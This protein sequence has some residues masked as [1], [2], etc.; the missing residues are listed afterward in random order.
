M[1]SQIDKVTLEVIHH[2]LVSI[3]DEMETI[4][5]KS[6]FSTIVKEARDATTALFDAKART[7]AQACA[8]PI[9]LGTMMTSVPQIIDGLFS[10]VSE[11]QEG[12][13]Y[14]AN[15]PY[16]GGT[17]MPDITMVTPVIYEDEV[18]AFSC[19][20]VHHQDMG[21]VTGGGSASATSI[22]H[23]GLNLPPVK[24]IVA[25]KPVKGIHDIIRKNV[26]TPD[27]V[28]GDLHAQVAAGNVGRLRILEL[29]EEYGKKMALDAMNQLL[30]YSEALTREE[31]RNMPDKSYSFVDYLDNDG[32]EL[33]KSVKLQIEVTIRGSDFIVDFTG[34]NPQ[35]KGPINCTPSGALAASTYV[36]RAI[37]DRSIPNNDGCFRVIKLILPEESIVNPISP[38]P[39]GGRAMTIPRMTDTIFGALVKAVPERLPAC[40][41]G[42]L[43]AIIWFAGKDP[44]TGKEY[45][46]LEVIVA[47]QGARPNKDGVD[48]VTQ[49]VM[50][51]TNVPI[52]AAE[53]SFPYRVLKIELREDSGGAGEYRGGLGMVKV[54]ELLRGQA[55]LICRGERFYTQPWGVFGG[56]PGS[57]ASAFVLRKGGK[58][59]IIPSKA[60]LAL[61]EGDQFHVFT[62]GGGGYGDPLKRS[63]ESVLRDVLDRR[64]SIESAAEEY[65]VVIDRVSR[66]I[67]FKKTRQLRKEKA[68]ARG[69]VTWT[70]DRGADGKI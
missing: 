28:I 60:D 25:G 57:N 19:S 33:E 61:N 62:P 8:I 3:A 54:F 53:M 9:H 52:E 37:T 20:V 26:R 59:E 31:I 35:V 48:A 32:I 11:M 70:Y 50:N 24:F 63:P 55:T 13:A 47:G 14:I 44:L 38:A 22:Y 40:S 17:H 12:D 4:L 6:S 18:V 68:K 29:I 23:E 51:L 66:N 39:V 46:A 15:D 7:I 64:V 1:S 69:P 49:D 5:L 41:G 43:G 65:G 2:R 42:G 30:D 21:A 67:D 10:S 36:L 34:S 16:S 58:K 56:L 45:I 27:A